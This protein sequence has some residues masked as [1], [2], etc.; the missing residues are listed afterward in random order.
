MKFIS[1]IS[2]QLG[3]LLTTKSTKEKRQAVHIF[4]TKLTRS[5]KQC[6]SKCECHKK[7]MNLFMVFSFLCRNTVTGWK[8]SLSVLTTHLTTATNDKTCLKTKKYRNYNK[9]FQNT[10][11]YRKAK[12]TG[13]TGMLRPLPFRKSP[14]LQIKCTFCDTPPLRKSVL[15]GLCISSDI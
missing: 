2:G 15:H 7:Q 3:P 8:M 9:I 4:S 5:Q 14:H 1:G 12:K 6:Q 13:N 10:R 11:I